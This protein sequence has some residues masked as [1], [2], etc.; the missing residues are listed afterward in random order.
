MKKILIIAL[1]L[2][3]SFTFQKCNSRVSICD[4]RGRIRSVSNLI[5][6]YEEKIDSITNGQKV[7]GY[8]STKNLIAIKKELEQ[9]RLFLVKRCLRESGAE[10]HNEIIIKNHQVI[11]KTDNENN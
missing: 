1:V 8:G 9:N 7:V 6:R 5:I 4:D 3:C 10:I 11:W 2:L